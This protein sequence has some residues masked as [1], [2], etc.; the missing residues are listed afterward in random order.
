MPNLV[1][2]TIKA[3]DETAGGFASVLAR[4]YALKSAMKDIVV[5]VGTGGNVTASLVSIKQKVQSIGL[6]DIA[7]VNVQPGILYQRLWYIKRAMQ[8]IGLGDIYGIGSKLPTKGPTNSFIAYQN[9]T[10]YLASKGKG[11]D[12]SA[13]SGGGGEG[14][15]GGIGG[16]IGGILGG[17]FGGGGSIKGGLF[18]AF[19]GALPG[20]LAV[21]GLVDLIIEGLISIG[22]AAIAAGA[23]FAVMAPTL[24]NIND[25]LQ[26]VNT[27]SKA[28]GQN[29]PPLNSHFQALSKAMAPQTIE[30]YGAGLNIVNQ[31]IKNMGPGASNVVNLFDTWAAKTVNWMQQQNTFGTIMRTGTVYLS[32]FGTLLG[33]LGEALGNLIQKDP[34]IAKWLITLLQGIAN[35]VNWFSQLPGPVVSAT[36]ALHGLWLWGSILGRI[37]VALANYLKTV[38]VEMITF[39]A[40]SPFALPAIFLAIA[41]A[42]GY[43]SYELTQGTPAVKNFLD[44]WTNLLN[45]QKASQFIY[46]NVAALG[47]MDAKLKTINTTFEN[48]QLNQM[49]LGN[50]LK[51]IIGSIGIMEGRGFKD[52]FTGHWLSGITEELKT[53][54]TIVLGGQK[55]TDQIMA[56]EDVSKIN[57]RINEVLGSERN[58]FHETGSLMSQ[59]F[60]FSQ[61]MG[62]MDLA[63]VKQSDTFAVMRTKVNDLI[64]GY[65]DMSVQGGILANSVNAVT[66][67]T[68]LQD[69]HV[70]TLT[71][72]WDTFFQTV[73]GGLSGYLSA[74][75]AINTLQSGLQQGGN[76]SGTDTQS[77]TNQQNAIAAIQA[78][79]KEQ[80]AMITAA[81]AANM[82][83]QGTKNI[84]T[85]TKDYLQALIPLIGQNQQFLPLLNAIAQ[86]GGMQ[87]AAGSISDLAKWAGPPVQN[88]LGQAAGIAETFDT[89]IQ[90]LNTDVQNLSTALGT[91]L[92]DA[93]HTAIFMAAGGQKPFTNFA[94]A[95]F[96]AHGNLD[97]M[98]GSADTLIGTL[99]K[100]DPSHAKQ[101]FQDFAGMLGLNSSQ[102]NKLW[103]NDLPNLQK[104]IDK[105]TGKTVTVNVQTVYSSIGNPTPYSK[106]GGYPFH[107]F[108]G[109]STAAAGGG[110]GGLTMVGEAGAELLQLPGGTHVVPH[111]NQAAQLAAMGGGGGGWMA[112][113]SVAPGTGNQFERLLLQVI[114]LLVL[115][116]GGGGVNSVQRAFGQVHP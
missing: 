115:K 88:P 68:M 116:N 9:A 113:V 80:D 6:A 1:E 87:G 58:L 25:H 47:A 89:K 42:V 70:A 74:V 52:F 79:Q 37:L 92:T 29:I 13:I 110:K 26:A 27:V 14:G 43:M 114:R 15:G 12:G 63:G 50:Q 84:T 78:I 97:L 82:G 24:G 35:L 112:Q 109:I 10:N 65:Q 96:T 95:V 38:I 54:D 73:S 60:S 48:T 2:I 106:G 53:L 56:Q 39:M 64:K 40:E 98:Q 62:L 107:A 91:T 23:G 81:A 85:A 7:D 108:G 8:Q 4:Y 11:P 86:Q 75:Q 59:G 51:T 22:S 83:A 34:G 33:T 94:S 101:L 57:Q 66:F 71:G 31:A 104:G 36:L 61:S 49:N 3:D 99:K 19:A 100:L 17:I 67:Q 102:A 45:S 105:L 18:G 77:I 30:L 20:L 55:W 69:S 16:A 46:S 90:N 76:L 111:G 28:L 41:A 44:Q 103:Q 72:A 93:M 21:H 5:D 32:M